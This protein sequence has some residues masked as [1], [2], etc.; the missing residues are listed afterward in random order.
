MDF[1]HSFTLMGQPTAPIIPAIF[2][3]GESLGASG[4]QILE[5]Y[6][7]GFEV[8]GNSL[9]RCAIPSMALG[10]PR[11]LWDLLGLRPGARSFSE[12]MLLKLKWR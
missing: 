10:M 6:T 3:L 9:I 11:A 7:T 1:D 2:A 5:S 8:T 4:R 12:S